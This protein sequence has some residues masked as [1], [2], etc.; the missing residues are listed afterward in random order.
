VIY[1]DDQTLLLDDRW[2]RRVME[3][4]ITA[5]IRVGERQVTPGRLTFIATYG[6]YLPLSV[7]VERLVET[8]FAEITNSDAFL[9]GYVDADFARRELL[10]FYPSIQPT[11]PMTVIRFERV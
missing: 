8:T 10:D 6:N 2:F 9:A 7:Y 11:T 1:P 5:S 3:G 4:S